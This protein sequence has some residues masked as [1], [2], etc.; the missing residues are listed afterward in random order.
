LAMVCPSHRGRTWSHHA[1]PRATPRGR[2]AKAALPTLEDGEESAANNGRII[3]EPES[4]GPAG[5]SPVLSVAEGL[6]MLTSLCTVGF[7]RIVQRE[8]R[9]CRRLWGLVV[10][11]CG[12]AHCLRVIRSA[13]VARH[14]GIVDGKRRRTHRS[15]QQRRGGKHGHYPLYSTQHTLLTLS[16]PLQRSLRTL[17]GYG[18]MRKAGAPEG[19][20]GPVLGRYG[21][22]PLANFLELRVC[23]L[24]RTPFP[25]DSLDGR[26]EALSLPSRA[27]ASA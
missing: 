9:I 11:T 1:R 12:M 26:N 21:S 8:G 25:R 6:R 20:P 14:Y 3:A 18:S 27:S 17:G 4:P 15:Y 13:V 7:P 22:C 10:S 24:R 23:E 16:F 5:Y 2:K 19:Y